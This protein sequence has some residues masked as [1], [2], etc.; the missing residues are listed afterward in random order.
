[1]G[2]KEP[3]CKKNPAQDRGA[4][5]AVA[6]TIQCHPPPNISA[7]QETQQTLLSVPENWISGW[8]AGELTM[9][10]V[11]TSPEKGMRA[12]PADRALLRRLCSRSVLA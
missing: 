6:P 9:E 11:F 4:G 7:V 12:A 2:E 1:M 5:A 3:L 8:L 10:S